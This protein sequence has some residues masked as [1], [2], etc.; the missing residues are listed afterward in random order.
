[1]ATGLG[2]WIAFIL[3]LQL[4]GNDRLHG[5]Q[6]SGRNNELD[7]YAVRGV[8]VESALLVRDVRVGR[9]R[10]CD[11]ERQAKDVCAGRTEIHARTLWRNGAVRDVVVAPAHG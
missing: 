10:A 2:R 9:A 1:M 7:L 8:A 4:G 11:G 5:L 6:S 3:C